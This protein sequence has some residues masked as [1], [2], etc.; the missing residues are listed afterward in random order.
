MIA[1]YIDNTLEKFSHEIKYSFDFIFKT[2]GYE[3]KYINRLEE[4]LDKDILV[5]YGLVEP[6]LKEAYIL[7]MR[8]A[9]I[10]VP[11]DQEL[12]IP[13]SIKK[14]ELNTWRKEL[15]L[16]KP[17]PVLSFNDFDAPVNYYQDDEL[18]YGTFK[19]D[20]I[21]NVF[22]NL[23]NFSSSAEEYDKSHEQ[24]KLDD[25]PLTPHL[26]YFCWLIE[27]CLIDAVNS[28]RN[29]FLVKKEYRVLELEIAS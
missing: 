6:N 18:F 4:L 1:V 7:A 15:T 19:F 9:I 8:K 11:C 3:F 14:K 26:N 22:F 20:L 21:G 29:I 25:N 28:R 2:L 17:I 23:T 12:F 10:F 24:V 27:Q 13:G 16:H 5:F